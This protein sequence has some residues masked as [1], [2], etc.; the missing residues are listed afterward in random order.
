MRYVLWRWGES[1]AFLFVAEPLW[2]SGWCFGLCLLLVC[3]VLQHSLWCGFMLAGVWFAGHLLGVLGLW[4]RGIL[5]R[6]LGGQN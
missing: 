1:W 5:C 4:F 2:G 3:G 6:E